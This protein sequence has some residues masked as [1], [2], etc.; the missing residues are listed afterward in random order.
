M[1]YPPDRPWEIIVSHSDTLPSTVQAF[2]KHQIDVRGKKQVGS[3]VAAPC[4]GFME[5]AIFAYPLTAW[6]SRRIWMFS[7][8]MNIDSLYNQLLGL[9]TQYT[10]LLR[11]YK[12]RLWSWLILLQ[13]KK[14]SL[15]YVVSIH[16]YRKNSVFGWM[17]WRSWVENVIKESLKCLKSKT[18]WAPIW[19]HLTS[20]YTGY[21]QNTRDMYKVI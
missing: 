17:W 10:W 12:T 5:S 16:C 4:E 14:V 11:L 2:D 9:M 20:W 6:L 7:I 19:C 21:G 3:L 18:L 1:P 15:F 8:I 13:R